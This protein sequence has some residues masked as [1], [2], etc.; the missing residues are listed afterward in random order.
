MDSLEFSVIGLRLDGQGADPHCPKLLLK[1]LMAKELFCT[2]LPRMPKDYITRLVF[3]ANHE[4]ACLFERPTN[5][6]TSPLVAAICYRLF[7]DER[8]IEIAFCAVSITR[9]YTGLGQHIMNLL[10]EHVKKKGYADIVTYADNAALEYFQKQGFSRQI[11]LPEHIWRGR[12]K[13]YDQAIFVQCHLYRTV[14]YTKISEVIR[15]QRELILKRMHIQ[16]SHFPGQLLDKQSIKPEDLLCIPSLNTCLEL[17]QKQGYDVTLEQAV[18][19]SSEEETRRC[20]HAAL[21]AILVEAGKAYATPFLQPPEAT[22]WSPNIVY[23]DLTIMAERCRA[24]FY[25]TRG[26]FVEH[27]KSIYQRC[28]TY[29]GEVA[30]RT[31]QALALY[32]GLVRSFDHAYNRRVDLATIDDAGY[33]CPQLSA[34]EY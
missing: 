24:G 21:Y 13:H 28:Q 22:D 25:R 6:T 11:T 33:L 19:I 7:P 30:E 10:K 34:K 15:R 32:H 17:L 3:N 18:G 14:D 1:L 20:C 2:A 9:Q 4:T 8:F 31:K 27:A 26:I 29:N 16:L 23:N 12:V 5:K